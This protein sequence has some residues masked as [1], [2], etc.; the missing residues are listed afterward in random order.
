MITRIPSI[1][2][3]GES[4]L[5]DDYDRLY[6]FFRSIWGASHSYVV[7][8]ARRCLNLNEIF[9][10]VHTERGEVVSNAERMISNN[11]LLLY[12]GEIAKYYA[13]WGCFPSILLADDMIYHGRGIMTLLHSLEELVVARLQSL[14]EEILNKDERYY[15]HRDLACAVEIRAFG[16]NR[17]PLLIDDL[18]AQNIVKTS[19][20]DTSELRKLSQSISCFI[21]HIGEPYTSYVLSCHVQNLPPEV[22]P[23][24]WAFQR[25]M[26]RGASQ[27]IFFQTGGGLKDCEGLLPTVRLRRKY[28]DSKRADVTLTGL[29]AFG[30]VKEE[31]INHLSEEILQELKAPPFQRLRTVPRILEQ[32]DP[33]C[34]KPRTQFLSLLMSVIALRQFFEA[35]A[36][37]DEGE[38]ICFSG[39]EKDLEKVARNFARKQDILDELDV[40]LQEP[41]LWE[42]L[43]EILY[44]GF[45]KNAEPF[46]GCVPV[47]KKGYHED[48]VRK[49][50]HAV[51]NLFYDIGMKS[52]KSAW[53][54]V[55]SRSRFR[56]EEPDQDM[57][58]LRHYIKE[59]HDRENGG[60]S[61]AQSL[62]CML[63]QMD[64]GLMSMNVELSNRLLE[65]DGSE[66]IQCVLKAGELAT[67]IKPR[68]Y[69]LFIPALA[70]V[71]RDSNRLNLDR[72]TAVT[73]F[74]G[75]LP[76]DPPDLPALKQEVKDEH[77]V[78]QELKR[79]GGRFVERLYECGQ[80]LS[81]W[82]INLVTADD[83]R[84]SGRGSYLS[85]VEN[86]LARR[87][88]Y[89]DLAKAFLLK[90]EKERESKRQEE[91][92]S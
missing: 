50:N 43:R 49:T 18:Y 63:S 53:Q 36:L 23:Q 38:R 41:P 67:F 28:D 87:R 17:Q 19:E 65:E 26:Y 82:D 35:L 32:Q 4:I 48:A 44:E 25:W 75:E 64:N 54:T 79:F 11:A 30:A 3:V 37:E 81:G 7:L 70:L 59:I 34:Q 66:K 20:R 68:Y 73:R 2:R 27:E 47:D 13:D 1:E 31:V 10:Q 85:F 24:K 83:W 90:C 55:D 12:A 51:E 61:K 80:S 78:L 92:F 71:E 45:R 57:I 76:E 21:Q 58:S 29:V 15:I 22:R 39:V 89:L 46:L 91:R 84:A 9:M 16:V 56:P 72:W 77:T 5:H 86:N 74:I 60:I 33:L 6:D 14:Q 8:I 42:R 88:V 62:C 40:L 69:H 52:E